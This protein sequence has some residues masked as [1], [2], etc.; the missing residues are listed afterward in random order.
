[1]TSYIP[2]ENAQLT[3]LHS[4]SHDA[5]S[6]ELIRLQDATAL[7]YQKQIDRLLDAL[8]DLLGPVPTQAGLE[9]ARAL[10]RQMRPP[11]AKAK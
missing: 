7:L 5:I 3:K 2:G 4:D 1:M 6:D 9:Q 10:V 11:E 8:I